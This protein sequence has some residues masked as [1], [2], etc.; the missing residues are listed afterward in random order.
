MCN[1]AYYR[2]KKTKPPDISIDKKHLIPKLEK[3]NVR[4]LPVTNI[5][6]GQ[7]N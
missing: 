1:I 5:N 7:N 3:D 4:K 2:I 6:M